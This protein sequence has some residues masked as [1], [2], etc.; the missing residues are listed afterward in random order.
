MAFPANYQKIWV[1]GRFV[2]LGKAA[3]GETNIGLTGQVQFIP[4]PT[5]LLDADLKLIIGTKRFSAT[6]AV[7]DGYFAIELPSTND[8]QINPSAWTYQV[9]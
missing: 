6:P 9:I 4:S 7:S 3:R 8:P 5:T 2:D 1:R